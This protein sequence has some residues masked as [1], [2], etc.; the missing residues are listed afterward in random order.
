MAAADLAATDPDAPMAV[1]AANRVVAASLA[2][3]EEGVGPGL[4]RRE[5]QARCPPLALVPTDPAQEARAFEDVLRAIEH[6]T[7]S[8]HWWPRP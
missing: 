2:A 1:M 6:F 3:R 4:R 5:A 8:P 7:P